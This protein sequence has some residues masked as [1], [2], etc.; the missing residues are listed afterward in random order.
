[1]Q[2][3]L[4]DEARFDSFAVNHP[5]HNYYQTS[6]YGKLMTKN[7]HNAYYL[8]LVDDTGEVKAATLMIV[9]NERA[10]KKKMG[11][12]PRGFIIDWEDEELVK[13]FTTELK[14]F[15]SKRNFTYVKIDPM[16][17][18]KEHNLDGSLKQNG[19]SNTE[20]TKKLQSLGY[21]H[22][23]YNNGFEASK[24]RWNSLIFMNNDITTLY[25][26]IPADARKKII[27][28]SKRGNRVYKGEGTDIPLL[29]NLI[30]ST[31]PP[32]EYYYDYQ[33][34]YTNSNF[35]LYFNKLEPIEYINESKLLYEKEEQKNHDLAMQMQ[36]F[37][38]YD[39]NYIINQ[40]LQSDEILTKYKRNMLVASRL[41]T[42]YPN[43]LVI[44][45]VAVIKYG[46]TITFLASGVNEE[47]RLEYPEYLLK[48]QLIEYFAKQ[49]YTIVNLGGLTNNFKADYNS[50]VKS[51]LGNKLVEYVGEFDLVINKKAYYTGAKLN[52][53]FNWLN[54]PI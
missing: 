21:I 54:T 15:L 53:I 13:T 27:D 40:K 48:W 25:N 14:D 12:C 37:S 43:G 32:I 47:F 19:T 45:G 6:N 17:I 34:F 50:V 8:G 38:M 26:S 49:G 36:D 1:M 5:R 22:M 44:A 11:Y 9:K 23:G 16:V 2:I 24:P 51:E 39:K 4:L 20:F 3:I 10:E 52:P 29:F 18:Y 42:K 35:E 33:K 7:G 28:A 30:N 31:I 41:F 46:K